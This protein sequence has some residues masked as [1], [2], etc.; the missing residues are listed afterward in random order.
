MNELIFKYELYDAWGTPIHGISVYDRDMD[1]VITTYWGLSMF[2]KYAPSAKTYTLKRDGLNR[3]MNA[4]A[5]NIELFDIHETEHA[6][7][8][9]GVINKFMFQLDVLTNDL[10]AYNLWAFE[11][12]DRKSIDGT[13]EKADA[14]LKVFNEIKEVLLNNGV[15][16]KYLDLY[17]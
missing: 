2:S 14:V 17:N 12:P 3:I 11:D 10:T 5:C 7:C 6:L 15:N 8:I 4:M 13:R 9:D 1:N 16:S